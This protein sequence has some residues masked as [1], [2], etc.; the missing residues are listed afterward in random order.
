MI[1][2]LATLFSIATLLLAIS[3]NTFAKQPDVE[4]N[5]WPGDIFMAFECDEFFIMGMTDFSL[6]SS[7]YYDRNGD[8]VK[9]TRHYV[10]KNS[11]YWNSENPDIFYEAGGDTGFSE[12]T[13]ENGL[14]V[15]YRERG[16]FWHIKGPKGEK[17]TF[18]AGLGIYNFATDVYDHRGLDYYPVDAESYARLCAY[19]SE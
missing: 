16:I 4:R 12:V 1:K 13:Y 14:P 19:F 3:F 9:T 18:V 15:E 10:A 5:Y 2:K 11:V 7:R 8:L 17:I 6:M